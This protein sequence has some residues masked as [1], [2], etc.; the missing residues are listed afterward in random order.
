ME[1]HDTVEKVGIGII[2]CGNISAAYLQGATNFPILDIRGVADLHAP[3]AQARATEFGVPCRTVEALLADP[4][5]DIIVNL[6]IPAA[7]VEVGLQVLHAGKHVYSEKPLGTTTAQARSLLALADARGLRVG[8]APDTFL[9]G[10]QQTCR[11]LVDAGAIGQPVAGTA[12]FLCPGHERWHPNPAFYYAQGGGPMLDMGPYYITALVN[13]VGPVARVSG[14]T[15]RARSQRRITSEPLNG[16]LI[17]VE[18]AT[19]VAGTLEFASGAVVSMATSFDVPRHRHSPIELYGTE[20]SLLVP[21]PN[22]FGGQIELARPGEDWQALPTEHGWADGTLRSIGVADMAHAIR[23]D[24][25]HRASGALALHVLEVM[26]AFQISSDTG[27]HVPIASR[28]ERPPMLP[29]LHT[30]SQTT[31]SWRFAHAEHA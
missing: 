29:T 23:A 14:S 18:V 8:C 22:H 13:L 15:L 31:A 28:P 19:H 2:G 4:A 17:E 20:A 1:H 3:A 25:P 27:R 30:V 10:A 12:F 7:H 6:T 5:I 21:D 24:R 16:S 26:E 11:K 9:G